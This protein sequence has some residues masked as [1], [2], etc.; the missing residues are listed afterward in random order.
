[1]SHVSVANVPV[2]KALTETKIK[3]PD[4]VSETP[5]VGV[6]EAEIIVNHA[7]DTPGGQMVI[8]AEVHTNVVPQETKLYAKPEKAPKQQTSEEEIVTE[9][10]VVNQP[11]TEA[12]NDMDVKDVEDEK[13]ARNGDQ[14]QETST[15]FSGQDLKMTPPDCSNGSSCS[16]AVTVVN[17]DDING[18]SA[19]DDTMAQSTNAMEREKRLSALKDA[20]ESQDKEDVAYLKIVL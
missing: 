11:S 6:E 7:T 16:P 12:A 19:S 20:W 5:S 10:E 13:M 15:K 17:A 8:R 1:M 14:M 18:D 4:T 2:P 9:K 3:E